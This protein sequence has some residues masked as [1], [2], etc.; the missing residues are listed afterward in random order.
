MHWARAEIPLQY[1]H[2]VYDA[3]FL[4]FIFIHPFPSNFGCILVFACK[5]LCCCFCRYSFAWLT[6]PAPSAVLSVTWV[7]LLPGPGCRT[8]MPADIPLWTY[9]AHAQRLSSQLI[10]SVVSQWVLLSIACT[11]CVMSALLV[12]GI[13]SPQ[14]GYHALGWQTRPFQISS[15]LWP[16]A[17][18]IELEYLSNNYDC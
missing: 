7:Q 9:R 8:C 3:S 13:L 5:P 12:V 11:C 14:V 6:L 17:V 15:R 18:W 10:P 1:P 16:V 2:L 4:V